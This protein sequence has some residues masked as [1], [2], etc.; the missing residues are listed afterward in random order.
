M[1]WTT[2]RTVD[3]SQLSEWSEGPKGPDLH[4]QALCSQAQTERRGRYGF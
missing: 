3:P 1:Q 4:L 2:Y